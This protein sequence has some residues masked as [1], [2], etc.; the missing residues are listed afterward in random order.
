M[1]NIWRCINNPVNETLNWWDW[2]PVCLSLLKTGRN[3]ILI[4]KRKDSDAPEP[5]LAVLDGLSWTLD[6]ALVAPLPRRAARLG[7]GLLVSLLFG[8]DLVVEKLLRQFVSIV[9]LQ[10]QRQRNAFSANVRVTSFQL[11]LV[12]KPSSNH[13]FRP[14]STFLAISKR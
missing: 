8:V 12:S 3:I 6:E 14:S 11:Q 5:S 1:G 4:Q 9:D 7:E 13:S 10:L 2:I